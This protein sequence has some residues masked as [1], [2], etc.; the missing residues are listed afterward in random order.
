MTLDYVLLLG[1]IGVPMAIV[2]TR[3]IDM[4]ALVYNISASLWMLPI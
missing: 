2:I 1:A 4:V 3:T